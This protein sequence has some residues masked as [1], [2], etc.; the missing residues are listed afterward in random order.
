MRSESEIRKRIVVLSNAGE[1]FYDEPTLRAY[2]K[3]IEQLQ[4]V[5]GDIE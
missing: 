2:I 5:L 3:A 4:W 1:T